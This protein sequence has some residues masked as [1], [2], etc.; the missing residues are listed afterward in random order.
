MPK[1]WKKILKPYL[2]FEVQCTI[3]CDFVLL[4]CEK[5]KSHRSHNCMV[6]LQYEWYFELIDFL[7]LQMISCKS[8]ND[9]VS[10][11]YGCSHVQPT[12][13]ETGTSCH[14]S[15]MH[16]LSDSARWPFPAS[17]NIMCKKPVQSYVLFG[18]KCTSWCD[19]SVIKRFPH[20]PQL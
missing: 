3:W 11:Q 7:S 15:D 16:G 12:G 2:L 17:L 14:N 6:S 20:I 8:H 18:G 1:L 10:L 4:F 19:F 9:K 5:K 13:V